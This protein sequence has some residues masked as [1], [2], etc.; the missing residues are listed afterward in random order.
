MLEY[1]IVLFNF[2]FCVMQS[3]DLEGRIIIWLQKGFKHHPS[4]FSPKIEKLLRNVGVC[5]VGAERKKSEYK[6]VIISFSCFEAL[7]TS[8]IQLCCW[9]VSLFYLNSLLY[10][11]RSRLPAHFLI[12]SHFQ[13]TKPDSILS[14]F[15]TISYICKNYE[16]ETMRLKNLIFVFVKLMLYQAFLH[17]CGVFYI[18]HFGTFSIMLQLKCCVFLYN[19]QLECEKCGEN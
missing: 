14:Y 19:E 9:H 5:H 16:S 1:L 8:N 13:Y 7:T 18:C 15:N 4:L 3:K 12:I 10:R 2:I 17:R 11:N 6:M